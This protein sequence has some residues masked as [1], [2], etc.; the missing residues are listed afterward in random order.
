MIDICIRNVN[1]IKDQVSK[2]IQVARL[3]SPSQTPL[4]LVDLELSSAVAEYVSMMAVDVLGH[5]TVV[6]NLIRPDTVV[7]ADPHE[8]EVVF[9]NLINNVL[10]Y[11][12]P[13]SYV[14][15]DAISINGQATITVSDNGIGLAATELD[16]VFDVFYKADPSRHEL[17]SSGL[18]LS[19]C[20]QIVEHHGGRIWAES[21]GAGQGT[22]IQ[23]TLVAGGVA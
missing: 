16:H 22:P 11:S 12:Q 4:N 23:L 1:H 6:E 14:G 20:R 10:I 8:L 2:T 7:Q 18:G 9:H 17:G 15:I 19:I 21:P 13:N 5:G 3:S